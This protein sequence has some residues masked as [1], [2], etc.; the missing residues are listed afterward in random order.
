M[1]KDQVNEPHALG[2]L[3]QTVTPAHACMLPQRYVLLAHCIQASNELHVQRQRKPT[4]FSF[5]VHCSATFLVLQ[6]SLCWQPFPVSTALH[7][8]SNCSLSL[9]CQTLWRCEQTISKSPLAE[10]QVAVSEK[11]C[12]LLDQELLP[13]QLTQ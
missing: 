2:A 7:A 13:V 9:A 1:S 3:L 6:S 11:L 8:W 12:L 4:S 10:L 5:H